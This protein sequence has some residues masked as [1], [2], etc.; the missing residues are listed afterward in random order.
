MTETRCSYWD[1]PGRTEDLVPGPDN[2]EGEEE[3]WDEVEEGGP[4]EPNDDVYH[5]SCW[6]AMYSWTRQ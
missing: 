4:F 3:D 2:N 1:C 5:D 6:T